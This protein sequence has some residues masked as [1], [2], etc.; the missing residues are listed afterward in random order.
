MRATIESVATCSADRGSSREL[1]IRAGREALARTGRA[2]ASLGVLVSTGINARIVVAV[3]IRQ[4]RILRRPAATVASRIAGD[5]P[6][7]RRGGSAAEAL[8]NQALRAQIG[9][10]TLIRL[11]DALAH[12][13]RSAWILCAV[14]SGLAFLVV[15]Q[16]PQIQGERPEL[17]LRARQRP[18]QE[19]EALC[20]REHAHPLLREARRVAAREGVTLRTLIERGLHRVIADAE[21]EKP[22]KLRRATFKGNGLRP[23]LRDG[24]WEKMRDLAYEGRGG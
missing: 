8:I 6:Q 23:D 11:Q 3:V 17:R 15:L 21:R 18:P 13:L 4:G 14:L 24:D 1:A 5:V 2:A 10:G 19:R 20:R 12:S 22:F 16:L 7:I 9:A